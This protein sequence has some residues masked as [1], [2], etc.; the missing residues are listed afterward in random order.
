MFLAVRR[1]PA[2]HDLSVLSDVPKGL[3]QAVGILAGKA[4]RY[5][6]SRFPAVVRV[7]FVQKIIENLAAVDDRKV[8]V[9]ELHVARIVLRRMI[10]PTLRE[11]P[12]VGSAWRGQGREAPMVGSVPMCLRRATDRKLSDAIPRVFNDNQL[13][14]SSS[15]Q[16]F[17]KRLSRA[18]DSPNPLVDWPV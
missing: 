8:S 1:F 4:E 18:A 13:P 17:G 14:D 7:G 5:E 15:S 3:Y 2:V 16:A 6:E 11:M 9:A 12:P 10:R